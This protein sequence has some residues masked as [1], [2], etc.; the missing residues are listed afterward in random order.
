MSF[1]EVFKN[2]IV[3][4]LDPLYPKGP[5]GPELWPTQQQRGV[6]EFQLHT[7]LNHHSPKHTLYKPC[8]VRSDRCWSCLW[9]QTGTTPCLWFHFLPSFPPHS[10]PLPSLTED[11]KRFRLHRCKRRR[12]PYMSSMTRCLLWGAH[13]TASPSQAQDH[14]RPL[15]SGNKGTREGS[16]WF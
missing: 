3:Y 1:F 8:A 13:S 2:I 4:V 12:N 15:L 5:P 10:S 16:G 6:Y 9:P 11:R 14:S 7:C